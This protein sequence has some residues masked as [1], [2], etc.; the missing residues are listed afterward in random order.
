MT[1]INLGE[2]GALVFNPSR[3]SIPVRLVDTTESRELF[4]EN[5][6]GIIHH[7]NQ[8]NNHYVTITLIRL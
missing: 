4:L 6:S 1:I 2:I 8:R 7:R 5:V 3:L